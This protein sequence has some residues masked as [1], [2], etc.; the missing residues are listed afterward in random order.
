LK[1]FPNFEQIFNTIEKNPKIN[2]KLISKYLEYVYFDNEI[3]A[4]ENKIKE[5]EYEDENILE[6]NPNENIESDT[7]NDKNEFPKQKKTN[8]K[9]EVIKRNSTNK[10]ISNNNIKKDSLL[11]NNNNNNQNFQNDNFPIEKNESIKNNNK[12]L[13]QSLSKQFNNTLNNLFD[14]LEQGINDKLSFQNNR[15]N[16]LKQTIKNNIEFKKQKINDLKIEKEIDENSSNWKIILS[17]L[18]N[19]Y[20]E[21]AYLKALDSGDDLIFLRLIFLK[22][23]K[24]LDTISL[25]TNKKIMIRLNQISRCFMIEQQIVNFIIEFYNLN[26]IN[27]NLF[28][29]NELNDLMQSLFEI[30]INDDEIGNSAKLIYNKI[31][32]SFQINNIN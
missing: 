16:K 31:K 19:E 32:E 17:Y 4:N 3:I 9:K 27:L 11:N 15:I 29:E 8:N 6:N 7:D 20:Y 5:I 28:N 23:T 30:G 13:F 14:D 24:F 22:G 26:M 18:K 25:N 12:N 1:S 2:K 10:I 21:K